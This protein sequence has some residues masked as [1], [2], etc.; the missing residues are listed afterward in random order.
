MSA[1]GLLAQ[2]RQGYE[3]D[4]AQAAGLGP[5]TTF[6]GGRVFLL[7]AAAWSKRV[8]GVYAN[9]LSREQPELAH[10]TLL[11]HADG[12]FLISVRAPLATRQ[13]ADTLCRQFATGGGRAGAAGVNNL[14]GQ[15]LETF[16]A[17]F[18]AHS[19]Q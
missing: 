4:M 3:T 10:A 19:F 11:P 6:A 15:E 5:Y 7:P 8:V 14:P 12:G 1:S 9:L 16:L 18:A 2:L 17:A 13:G